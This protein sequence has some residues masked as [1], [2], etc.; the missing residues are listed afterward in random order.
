M[1]QA[2]KPAWTNWRKL[3][4]SST[5]SG[6]VRPLGCK[7]ELS[8]SANGTCPM[9]RVPTSPQGMGG[10]LRRDRA[11]ASHQALEVLP[12]VPVMATTASCAEGLS[13]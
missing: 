5:A 10:C 12:L 7:A 8:P 3:C 11:W 4:C 1:A 13:K 9:P 2:C 6:V